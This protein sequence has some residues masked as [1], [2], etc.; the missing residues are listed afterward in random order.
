MKRFILAIPL[1]I[2]LSLICVACFGVLVLLES[3]SDRR[4]ET[5]KLFD[6]LYSIEPESLLSEIEQGKTDVF[7]PIDV[8]PPWPSP[9]QQVPVPWTQAD[10][11]HIANVVIEHVWND[12]VDGWQI[13]SVYFNRGCTEYDIGFQTGEFTFFKNEEVNGNKS[14]IWRDVNIIPRNKTVDVAE[15]R[16]YPRLVDLSP[17]PL[18]ENLLSAEKALQKAEEEGGIEK[19]LS[20][21]NDCYISL[22]LIQDFSLWNKKWWWRARYTGKDDKG[23]PISIFTVD[24]S[25]YTGE[26]RP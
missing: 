20:V 22:S 23:R 4:E 26:L 24:I 21:T 10:Y 14:R 13:S 19:R 2:S 12:T 17:I 25:P 15:Y 7:S 9:D 16:A 3:M 1:P 8:E 6:Q 18:D 5:T 11:L